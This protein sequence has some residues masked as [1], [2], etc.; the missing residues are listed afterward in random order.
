MSKTDLYKGFGANGFNNLLALWALSTRVAASGQELT[1]TS[2]RD[3]V[4]KTKNDHLYGSTPLGCA[5]APPP[6]VAVCN[7]INSVNKWDGTN[8]VSVQENFSGADLVAG[9]ELKPGP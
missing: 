3:F 1:P 9:T 2:F 8:L 6:Y 5:T 4:A 7:T